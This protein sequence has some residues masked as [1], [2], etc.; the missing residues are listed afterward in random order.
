[1]EEKKENEN[2]ENEEEFKTIS[3]KRYVWPD[4]AALKE[5]KK[6]NKKLKKVLVGSVVVAVLFGWFGGSVL[7][8]GF[9]S[10]LRNMIRRGMTMSSSKKIQE[11]L[12]IMENDWYFSKDVDD[13]D[14]R[15][16][17]QAVSGIT[18]NSEDK[19]TEYM[20]KDEMESFTQSINRNYVGIGVQYINADGTA[21]IEKVYKNTPAQEAGVKPGDILYSVDG[22][23][24]SGKSSDEIKK[25]VQGKAGSIV[26]IGFIR[27]GKHIAL[28]IKRAE[29]S[30]TVYGEMKDNNIAYLQL[31]Q[32]GSTTPDEVKSYL[33]DFKDAS[34]LI[35]D[36]RDNGGGYLDSVSGVSSCFLPKGTKVMSQE[37][38]NG[39][40]TETDTKD[41]Q[42]SKIQNIV[43]LV[44]GNTA[45]AAEVLTLA[46]KQQRDDV[47]IIGT[48]TYGKGTVQVSKT[49]DDGSAIKYTTSKWLSPDGTWVNGVGITPDEEIHL[50]DVFYQSFTNMEE[51]DSYTVDSV[52]SSIS[53]AQLCLDYLGY[54]VDRKD[55]YFSQA[56]ADALKQYKEDHNL[57]SNETLDKETYDSLRSQ[58][59]LDWNTSSTH[60]LQ[61]KQAEEE[62]HG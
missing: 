60:D 6:K 54:S 18:T 42:Y 20:S 44:N 15:L 26:T 61:L 29:V 49:F 62:L 38:V 56:T 47:K 36:L 35:I 40:T 17:D 43:I 52:S 1:M 5:E 46:L 37:Y 58:V 10:G 4:E 19:H 12:D 25:A 3:L 9:T 28:D 13:I 41:E 7:P 8:Y 32:F 39:D 57:S 45:S 51:D 33:D 31:Y 14:D 2:K 34:G 22:V 55:G 30:S 16:T 23:E 24:M 27:N 48:T 59:I 50:H 11:A 21:I 53:D